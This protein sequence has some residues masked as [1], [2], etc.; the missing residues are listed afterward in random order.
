MPLRK[1]KV[2]DRDDSLTGMEMIL[3]DYFLAEIL[4]E[5][6]LVGSNSSRWKKAGV[7]PEEH[8]LKVS[9]V[10]GFPPH[11]IRP[12][13]YTDYVHKDDI[14]PQR[15]PRVEAVIEQRMKPGLPSPGMKGEFLIKHAVYGYMVGHWNGVFTG[16]HWHGFFSG[17]GHN[18]ETGLVQAVTFL[19]DEVENAVGWVEIESEPS[20]T[21]KEE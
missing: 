18:P 1:K 21:K 10:T 3:Q 19:K 20:T 16:G 15:A 14:R 6:G 7:V 17:V 2:K 12:D 5:I 11:L 9:Q 8:L 4:N 13:L